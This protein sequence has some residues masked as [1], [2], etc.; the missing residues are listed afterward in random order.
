MRPRGGVPLTAVILSTYVGEGLL[1][2]RPRG[3]VHLAGADESVS[4]AFEV[5]AGDGAVMIKVDP[6]EVGG[7]FFIPEFRHVGCC[8]CWSWAT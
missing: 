3:G 2:M 1:E 7:H 6:V 5:Q 4:H 8:C